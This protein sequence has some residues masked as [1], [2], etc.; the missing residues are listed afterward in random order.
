MGVHARVHTRARPQAAIKEKR[1][2]SFNDFIA[3][4]E[5]MIA[6]NITRPSKLGIFGESNGGLLVA[7]AMVQKPQLFAAV[8][9]QVCV[10]FCIRTS[11][12]SCLCCL[13]RLLVSVVE[14]ELA[15]LVLI[16]LLLPSLLLLFVMLFLA[17]PVA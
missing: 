16:L 14:M 2:K 7:A 12:E 13:G 1:Q 17:S 5:D 15:V 4:A 9:C 3:V 8:I 6:R 10:Y 11:G